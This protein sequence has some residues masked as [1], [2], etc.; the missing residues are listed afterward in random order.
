VNFWRVVPRRSSLQDMLVN[1]L[2]ARGCR[3]GP[4]LWRHLVEHLS[5]NGAGLLELEIQ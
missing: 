1:A 5:W 2:E 4:L 3:G